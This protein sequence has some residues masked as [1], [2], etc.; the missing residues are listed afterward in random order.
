MKVKK[1]IESWLKIHASDRKFSMNN[2]SEPLYYFIT[3][4]GRCGTM[5]YAKIFNTSVHSECHH[6][7]FFRHN[8]M[9]NFYTKRSI[10]GFLEDIQGLRNHTQQKD[11]SLRFFGISSGH[12]YFALPLLNKIFGSR[13]RYI[14]AVREPEG[15]VRSALARGFFDPAH[16]NYCEQLPFKYHDS[17]HPKNM[18]IT[19]FEKTAWYWRM[20]NEYTLQALADISYEQWKVLPLEK[21]SPEKLYE[22]SSWLGLEDLTL[23]QIS[24]MMEQRIN[25]S[26]V[27]DDS[28][29]MTKHELNPYSIA[30]NTSPLS[31]EEI[32]IL[33]LYTKD[34]AASI[35]SECFCSPSNLM[36]A[37]EK[38]YGAMKKQLNKIAQ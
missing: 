10:H 28:L 11:K 4:T 35:A 19:P 12:L 27:N 8:S 2:S 22:I 38:L 13:A 5:L 15:F 1:K 34:L 17:L 18:S 3:G 16:P 31:T 29:T 25:V 26:P 24:S 9:I 36:P 21:L 37:T 20:V 23:S 30:I 7:K 33:D 32:N 6:E 14:L